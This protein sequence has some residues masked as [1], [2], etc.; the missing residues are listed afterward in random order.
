MYIHTYIHILYTQLCEMCN[1]CG[2]YLACNDRKLSIST[3]DSTCYQLAVKLKCTACLCVL[4]C[5]TNFLCFVYAVVSKQWRSKEN[6]WAGTPQISNPTSW[7][8][9]RDIFHGWNNLPL[10]SMAD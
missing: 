8:L 3:V 10:V 5:I 1:Q 7:K 4:K 6:L 9:L 2:S